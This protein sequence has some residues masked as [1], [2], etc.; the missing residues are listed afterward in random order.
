MDDL[1]L[2]RAAHRLVPPYSQSIVIEAILRA[3][4]PLSLVPGSLSPRWKI[5]LFPSSVNLTKVE[6]Y[7]CGLKSSYHKTALS[8]Y[9]L[10]VCQY[11]GPFTGEQYAIVHTCHVLV[12]HR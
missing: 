11:S 5:L 3:A 4:H 1:E 6:S 12:I 7:I 2:L 8:F 10:Y 9:T